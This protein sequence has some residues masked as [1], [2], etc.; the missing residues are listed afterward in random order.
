M[1]EDAPAVRPGR[2]FRALVQYN[3]PYWPAYLSGAALSAVF[4]GTELSSPM[5]IRSLIDRLGDGAMTMVLLFGYFGALLAL[6]A[7][8]GIARFF[9]R[10]ILIGAS[11]EFEYDLRND[12][13]RHVQRLS[14]D[15]FNRMKTGDIMARATNDVGYVRML[16]GPGVMLSIDM[17]RLPFTLGLMIYISPVLTGMAL[18][19]LPF[20]S[21]LVYALVRYTHVQSRRVQDQY[22][23]MTARAQENLSGARVVK[24]F[25]IAD[26]EV[27][28]FRVESRRYM[29]E[30]IK[31]SI[32]TSLMWPLIGIVVGLAGLFV[33]WQGGSRVIGGSLT[34]GDLTGFMIYLILLAWPL[35]EL[36]WVVTLYQRAAVSM[37]RIAEVLIETPSIR[38]TDRT[39]TDIVAVRGS[40]VFDGVSFAYSDAPVLHAL[41]FAVREG[42]TVAITGAT[43]SG[44]STI[45]SLIARECDPTLGRVLVDG[46]DA[47]DI[48]VNVLR[49][50]I[51]YVPQ[52]AFF[53]SDTIRANLCL[54]RPDAPEEAIRHA[55]DVAR[56]QETVDA[57]PQ[58]LDTL[59]GERGVNLS[60][61][62][63][64]R[65]AVA[66][67]VLL[68]PRILAL[69][70]AFSSV[71]AHTEEEMLQRLGAFM[72]RRT[73]IIISHRVS[74][75]RHADAII[76]LD[77]GAI[78]ESGSHKEL[79]ERGGLYARMYRR[80]LLEE[81]LE[82]RP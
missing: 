2:P 5:V 47:R 72:T 28:A 70:D 62:Q 68:D 48:P 49:K 29:R 79:L 61:G 60:G 41:R 16:I 52:D 76:V 56:F 18:L 65:L 40:I 13:F 66:R 59:L 15:F 11:R 35:A 9:Q 54:G 6:A 50:A 69:D 82:R 34:L 42:E 7:G 74:T 1:F 58:G 39:R 26:R 19:P 20:V 45:A 10:R 3:L 57:L 4:V 44:K 51:G 36:G 81:E 27:D 71:D 63:K 33:L 21:A 22:G 53:F 31:L 32:A 73:S 43:G 12:Y 37:D 30:G 46:I 55:C 25:A 14:R 38:D 67:A 77:K 78:A 23:E 75:I 64:Q 24:A 8:S 80:Q 17:M